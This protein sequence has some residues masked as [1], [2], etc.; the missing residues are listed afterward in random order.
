ML[1]NANKKSSQTA[2]MKVCDYIPKEVKVNSQNISFTQTF[3]D[4]N[5]D[6]SGLGEIGKVLGIDA[7]P[8]EVPKSL[9]AS[10]GMGDSA[11]ESIWGV[12]VDSADAV[13]KL[14]KGVEI[15]NYAEL[16]MW[17]INQFDALIG[18]FPVEIEIEDTDVMKEGDQTKIIKI[19][20]I[21]EG[22]REIY[23]ANVIESLMID[24][25][26][27]I[28]MRLIPEITR[29][30]QECIITGDVLQACREFLGFKHKEV[31]ATINNNFNITADL[32]K[33]T[34]LYKFLEPNES[35]YKT[36]EFDGKESVLDYLL[37]LMYSASLSKASILKDFQS[38]KDFFDKEAERQEN[39]DKEQE[40]DWK[41]FKDEINNP[42]SAFNLN[43]KPSKIRDSGGEE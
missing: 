8:G 37:R 3:S 7:F 30:R 39:L 18:Q 14:N 42:E 23:G 27:N 32:A 26:F 36:I 38:V 13:S 1:V 10:S 34:D 33:I 4:E 29:I 20:N 43:E 21:A 12:V 11:L 15:K 6:I 16:F 5:V 35:K 40:E 31:E 2:L 24:G 19:A 25:N 9:L 28:L 22:I 17:Y 41:Q